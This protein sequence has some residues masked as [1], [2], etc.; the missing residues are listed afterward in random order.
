MSHLTY[1]IDLHINTVHKA[2]KNPLFEL[3][4]KLSTVISRFFYL[5]GKVQGAKI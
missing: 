2:K 3:V 4:L 5:Y 1:W